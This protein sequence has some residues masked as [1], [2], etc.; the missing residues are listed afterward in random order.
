M[1]SQRNLFSVPVDWEYTI[2]SDAHIHTTGLAEELIQ[3]NSLRSGQKKRKRSFWKSCLSQ[4][5]ADF[6]CVQWTLPQKP[7]YREVQCREVRSS[8]CCFPKYHACTTSQLT[9]AQSGPDP[10]P[11]HRIAHVSP[12]GEEETLS[13][14]ITSFLLTDSPKKIK[15]K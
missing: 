4:N 10:F 13:L 5:E 6:R 2:L 11:S 7:P 9:T 3:A 1:L 15:K 12:P 14:L 8:Q